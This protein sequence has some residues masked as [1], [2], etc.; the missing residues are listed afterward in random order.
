MDKLFGS[1][2]RTDSLVAIGR[3]GT[4]YPAELAR[5]LGRRPIEIQRAIAALEMAGAVQTRRVGNVRTVELNRRFPEYDQLASLLL[6][7]S[8]RPLYE[9][10]WKKLRRRP[11][12][13]GKGL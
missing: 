9:Q 4:T 3:L 13:M 12:A 2:L 6:R 1:Q 5:L 11:R 8:E 10:R 7:M